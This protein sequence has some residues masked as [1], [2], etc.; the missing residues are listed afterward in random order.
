M[1]INGI[2]VI[3]AIEKSAEKNARLEAKLEEL[4][5]INAV[6]EAKTE[7]LY[8]APGMPG[9]VAA[10]SRLKSMAGVDA[11]FEDP[12]CLASENATG[13]SSD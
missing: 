2:N 8:Y 7:E 13:S 11:C 3:E 6:L 5:Q 9:N 1:C 10:I 4:V 12:L